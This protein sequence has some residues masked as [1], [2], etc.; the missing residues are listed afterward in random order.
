MQPVCRNLMDRLRAAASETRDLSL[1]PQWLIDNT[2]NPRDPSLPWS[3]DRH[4]FQMAIA[5]DAASKVVIRKCSQVGLSELAVRMLLALMSIYPHS[6]AIYT[7]PTT[8]FAR[9]FAK[10][11]IDPV[12]K[13]SPLLRSRV[14]RDT[15]SSE[16]KLIGTSHLY[17]KGSFGQGAAISVPADIL[18]NDEVD[19]SNQM[20]LSTFAS[21]LG[22]AENGG[23]TREFS[24]P[25]VNGYG[26]SAS[27]DLSSQGR[28]GVHCPH[29]R[30]LV[31]PD[32]FEDVVLPGY[33][34]PL[35][36]WCKEDLANPDYDVASA[37][38]RCPSCHGRLDTET[39]ADPARREWVHAFEDRELRGYQVLPFDVPTINPVTRTLQQI[40]EYERK[41]DWVNFKVGIPHEDAETSFIRDTLQRYATAAAQL[42]PEAGATV[43]SGCVAGLDV[44]KTSWFV[45][46]KRV[47]NELLVIHA[48]RI[49]QTGEG[50]L[51]TRVLELMGMYGV[52]KLVV[53]SAPD[54]S[55][56]LALINQTRHGQ[57]WAAYYVRT[58]KKDLSN[59]SLNEA[60]Q[61]ITIK[62]TQSLD[63]LAKQVNGGR[64]R[65]SR[66]P[67]TATIIEHLT[68]LKRVTRDDSQGDQVASWVSTGE[69]HYAHAIHYLITAEALC[70][71]K[72]TTDV[73]PILPGAS[74]I[75][76][77]Q[78][79]EHFKPNSKMG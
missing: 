78:P 52:I 5:A 39:L 54:F 47:G 10:A 6:T 61:V 70:N 18:I 45:V 65:L 25:T 4:E 13:D 12:I 19:F 59:F 2:R 31:A 3:F 41:A 15:D 60:E 26:I 37:W 51:V 33:D 53:D 48:E 11:R 30:N 67:E 16:L 74:R 75:L 66:H 35:L 17:I 43:A 71:L 38:L 76:M 36:N 21:R 28:Y 77:K 79:K 63:D 57:V 72:S 68:N 55:T 7:L 9:Q 27:Y 40:D 34:E 62:R 23:I 32:F 14:N 24:T 44:G 64:L 49:R 50:Y 20:A 73:V 22:H 42:P 58:G 46:G 69:D 29:C 8:S 1:I 56:A